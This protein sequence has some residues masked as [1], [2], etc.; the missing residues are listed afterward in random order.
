MIYDTPYIRSLP[1]RL[2]VTERSDGGPAT[3]VAGPLY[4]DAF[5]N[6]L[7]IFHGHIMNGTKP[8]TNLLDSRRDL[9][10][11]ADIIEAMKKVNVARPRETEPTRFSPNGASYRFAV[12]Y[13]TGSRRAR[14]WYFTPILPV[15]YEVL[16]P[17]S[18]FYFISGRL[19]CL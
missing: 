3:R 15:S 10:L 2:E 4:V 13:G 7:T 19:R 17:G 9:A 6:E 12:R 8:L 11:M 14:V 5:S 16:R 18:S 1:T